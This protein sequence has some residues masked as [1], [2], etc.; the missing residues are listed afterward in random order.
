MQLMIGGI[1]KFAIA[2]KGKE[3]SEQTSRDN[4]LWRYI[5]LIE[6]IQKQIDEARKMGKPFAIV[7]FSTQQE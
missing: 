3:W 4:L 6:P 5:E 2:H 1:C 7:P